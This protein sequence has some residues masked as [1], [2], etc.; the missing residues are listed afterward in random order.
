MNVGM[1]TKQAVI[2]N[3]LVCGSEEI[4]KTEWSLEYVA[5]CY[6]ILGKVM[7]K[8]EEPVYKSRKDPP[9][10][11]I[12]DIRTFEVLT[13]IVELYKGMVRLDPGKI[14]EKATE[15]MMIAIENDIMRT[16]PEGKLLCRA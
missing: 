5:E 15:E 10:P 11:K 12:S 4:E 6:E 13:C 2:V 7:D 9:I 1:I 8:T 3:F 16:T 14:L